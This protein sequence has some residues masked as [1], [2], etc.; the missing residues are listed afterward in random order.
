MTRTSARFAARHPAR[1]ASPG[2][3][4]FVASL[5]LVA[6][7]LLVGCGSSTETM[8]KKL[9]RISAQ[10]L[11]D[12]VA[13]IPPKAKSVTL[14]KPYFRVDKYT[15]FHGDTA[16]VYQAMATVYFFYL[17]PSMGLCQLRQYRYKRT[18]EMWDR[19]EVRLIHTPEK[20]SGVSG[21]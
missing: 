16:I 2:L 10:D 14:V 18:S 11:Q 9:D 15:E 19:Y 17:D 13:E 3:L 20:F 4:V 8:Q 7:S 1:A 12:I 6:V 21:Q 5:A